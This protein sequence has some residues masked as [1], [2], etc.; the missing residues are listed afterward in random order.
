MR[1]RPALCLLT[2]L[3]LLFPGPFLAQEK[4]PVF[5]T[6]GGN[7]GN[8]LK[9]SN[10]PGL[11]IRTACGDDTTLNNYPASSTDWQLRNGYT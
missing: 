3:S 9:I 11:A 6:H 10:S 8:W 7:W 1:R 2:C 5:W 4:A